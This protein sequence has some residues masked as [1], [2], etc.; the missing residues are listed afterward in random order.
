MKI[1]IDIRVRSERI[2][3]DISRR[4]GGEDRPEID[5]F[6]VSGTMKT[7]KE[8][9]RIEFQEDGNFMIYSWS[10]CITYEDYLALGEIEEP[11]FP[12]GLQYYYKLI[13]ISGEQY[14][15]LWQQE[16]IDGGSYTL[17]GDMLTLEVVTFLEGES[18]VSIR[19][20]RIAG[21][22]FQITE[23]ALESW[24]VLGFYYYPQDGILAWGEVVFALST[25][26]LPMM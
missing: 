20:E 26:S 5:D 21:N 25:P 19:L 24:D 1:P 9:Y 10:K 22:A 13:E 2:Y 17:E 15:V 3:S 4:N 7:T 8:G 16:A 12:E 14:A 18:L 11:G 6:S 23:S